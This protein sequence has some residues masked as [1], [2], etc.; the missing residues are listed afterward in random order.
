MV[1]ECV[2]L[3]RGALCGNVRNGCE[4]L[5]TVGVN[6]FARGFHRVRQLAPAEREDDHKPI[7]EFEP[8]LVRLPVQH[9]ALRAHRS[10]WLNVFYVFACLILTEQETMIGNN[11]WYTA[12]ET[13]D[14]YP[15][16][17]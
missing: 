5:A 14:V 12:K 13:L 4:Y 2:R 9:E 17:V 6:E 10:A 3:W 11:G 7:V 8:R 15:L 1:A 16:R